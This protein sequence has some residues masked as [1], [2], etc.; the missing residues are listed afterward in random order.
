MFRHPLA[1]EIAV[2]IC[3]KVIALLVLFFAFFGPAQ[4]PDVDAQILTGH[5]LEIETRPHQASEM[6]R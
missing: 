2:I 5:L 1:R 4:R 3:L 6:K